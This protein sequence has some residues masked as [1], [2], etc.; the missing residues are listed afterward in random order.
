MNTQ[1][2]SLLTEYLPELERAAYKAPVLDLACGSGRNGLYL[3]EQGL[4]VIFADKNTDALAQIGECLADQGDSLGRELAQ[5]W[6]VDF[7][8]PGSSPLA[9]KTFGAV[10]VFRYLHRP[11]IPSIKNS[12]APGGM[13]IYETFTLA[14]R[15]FGRPKKDEFLLKAGELKAC[16]ADWQILHSFEGIVPAGNEAGSQ[17]IAQLVAFKPG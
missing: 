16:F 4:P 17:A 8:Q 1:P 6:P 13:I 12:I 9:S 15:E 10:M 14:Q 5:L 7:E 2:S 11:L 3:V